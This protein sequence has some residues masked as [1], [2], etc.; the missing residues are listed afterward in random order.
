MKFR[1]SS[2]SITS[3]GAKSGF[4]APAALVTTS[5]CGA[6]RPQQIDRQRDVLRASSPRRGAAAPASAPPAA[7]AA[8]RSPAARRGPARSRPGSPRSRVGMATGVARPRPPGRRARSRG[9]A[10]SRR[11][12]RRGRDRGEGR[13][14]AVGR[15]VIATLAAMR[16]ASASTSA[17]VSAMS[18][19]ASAPSRTTCRPPTKTWRTSD[20][21]QEKTRCVS[22]SN[23]GTACGRREVDQDH[24]GELARLER[25]EPVARRPAPP[26]ASSVTMRSA[27]AVVTASARQRR[28]AVQRRG[29]P[30][31]HPHVEVVARDRPV[32]AER[33][34][35]PGRQQVGHA[36]DAAGELQVRHRVVR[37]GRAGAR[38]DRDLLVV[39]PDAMREHGARVEQAERVEV[40]DHRAAVAARDVCLL[41]AGLGGVGARRARRGRPASRFAALQVLRARRCRR[42]AGR[43][44]GS[45]SSAPANSSKNASA[46]ASRAAGRPAVDAGAVEEDAAGRDA[47][48]RR[49]RAA[50]TVS[51]GCQNM[52]ITVV[53]PPSSSSAKPSVAPSRTVSRFRIAPSAFQ[54][55]LQPGLE[56]QI[57]DQPAEQAVGGVAVGVDQPGHQQHAARRRSPRAPRA[58]LRPG[59]IRGDPPARHRHRARRGAPCPPRP[60]SRRRR[61]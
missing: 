11:R 2:I 29:Q 52:S 10:R 30:Q 26:R 14:D 3:P 54:T 42:R 45:T 31:R 49:A 24:V 51:R 61:W 33:H 47:A 59:P 46:S 40:A 36:G 60:R 53:T 1:W 58:D 23:I 44:P 56:R 25:A 27:C 16:G 18:T 41:G 5:R 19:P 32:G 50:A 39:E 7:V 34:P 9:S 22:G 17:S 37:D 48:S 12:A 21:A 38:Q 6:E 8:R 35:H 43:S 20:L 4:S 13:R 57:L 15:R 28:A 55:G